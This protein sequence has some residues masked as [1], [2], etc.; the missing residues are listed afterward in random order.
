MPISPRLRGLDMKDARS[1]LTNLNASFACALRAR[2]HGSNE[3]TANRV[4]RRSCR[5]GDGR[6]C[7][8][9]CGSLRLITLHEGLG[10]GPPSDL[11][12]VSRSRTKDD[13]EDNENGIKRAADSSS[14]GGH[15]NLTTI[16][17]IE[18][19]VTFSIERLI[20]PLGW[21]KVFGHWHLRTI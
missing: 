17:N 8:S 20:S 9:S 18:L 5:S 19:S 16:R 12:K 13:R 3:H 21:S 11:N 7:A 15:S 10:A 4:I 6:A 1:G 14:A 2:G